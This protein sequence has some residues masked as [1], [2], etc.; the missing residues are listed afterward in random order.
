MEGSFSE[1]VRVVSGMPQGSVLGPLLFLILMIDI[2]NFTIRA[3]MG[4]FADDTR[5]W[6]AIRNFINASEL[7]EDLLEVYKWA[8]VNN[9][10]FNE[11]KFE[12]MSFSLTGRSPLYVTPTG[13]PIA[14]KEV[15]RDLGIQFED[16]LTFHIH[17]ATTAAKGHRMSGW[18]LR[19]FQIQRAIPNAHSAAIVNNL[20][21]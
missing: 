18:A 13:Q 20:P 14:K 4:S 7:Q 17:I 2:D 19:T 10:Q 9:M 3:A 1:P 11:N 15:I 8:D 5:L 12:L 21:C 6:H 16:N